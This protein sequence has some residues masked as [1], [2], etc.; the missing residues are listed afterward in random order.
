MNKALGIN[1]SLNY[2]DI[3]KNNLKND[4]ISALFP[5]F[6]T[7]TTLKSIKI[8]EDQ[9]FDAETVKELKKVLKSNTSLRFLDL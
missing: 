2:L 8:L 6:T 3:S 9:S 7:N 4:G 1:A 5:S